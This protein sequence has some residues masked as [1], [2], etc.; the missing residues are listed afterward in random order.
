MADPKGL[1]DKFWKALKSDRTVMLGLDGVEDGHARPMT[2]QIEG[3]SGGPIWFFTSKDNALIA[4]LGQGRRVI[5][6]FSSKGHDLFASISGSLREDTDPAV[7]DRL[8]NPYV[9]AWYEG[10]K[11]DPKLALLRLDADHAQIWLNGSS[12]LAGIKVLLG[13]DP[14]KDYQDKVA[15]VPLR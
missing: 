3:D 7:V 8:W 11:D 6:A 13:V 15:D 14:K 4:M 1:Q 12:L 9:A 2:A 5:G 10:G